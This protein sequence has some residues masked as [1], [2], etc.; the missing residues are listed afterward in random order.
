M[1]QSGGLLLAASWMA[2]THQFSFAKAKE[3]ANR[4][5]SGANWQGNILPH[6]FCPT[7]GRRTD[8]HIATLRTDPDGMCMETS[9]FS[10]ILPAIL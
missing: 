10:A 3:N 5:P 6:L 9:A 8:R 7:D 4:V 1:Q 2:A